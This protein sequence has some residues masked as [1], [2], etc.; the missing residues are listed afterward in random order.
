MPEQTQGFS[1]GASGSTKLAFLHPHIFSS[2]T[3][4][5]GSGLLLRVDFDPSD[6]NQTRKIRY[7]AK[8]RM[9]GDDPEFQKENIAYANVEKLRNYK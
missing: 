4:F 6:K 2:F 3:N 9:L 8:Y 7:F 1:I 5:A